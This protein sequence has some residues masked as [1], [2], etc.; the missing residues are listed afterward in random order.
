[1]TSEESYRIHFTDILLTEEKVYGIRFTKQE[2]LYGI[3]S[4]GIKELY[5]IHSNEMRK[6]NS[7]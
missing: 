4:T 2:E 1:M 5:G 7:F 3:H 6:V